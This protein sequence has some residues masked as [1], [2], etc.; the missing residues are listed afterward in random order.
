[1]GQAACF[2]MQTL[3][4]IILCIAN[5][6]LLALMLSSMVQRL[7]VLRRPNMLD[8]GVAS[9]LWLWRHMVGGGLQLCVGGELL[10]AKFAT[11]TLNCLT[12]VIGL[13]PTCCP[14]GGHEFQWLCRRRM[15][16]RFPNPL[17]FGALC[18]GH[19]MAMAPVDLFLQHVEGAT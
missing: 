11:A 4:C 17:A 19:P 12:W 15:Q 6:T 5:T 3:L 8:M 7:A 2:N 1:M 10:P 9:C 16:W 18:A 14:R 13:L